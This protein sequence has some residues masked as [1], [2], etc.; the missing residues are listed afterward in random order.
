ML[1]TASEVV[2]ALAATMFANED[3]DE[4]LMPEAKLR[5]VVVAFV[6]DARVKMP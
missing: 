4:A 3:V 2:V 1:V 5:K 6:L